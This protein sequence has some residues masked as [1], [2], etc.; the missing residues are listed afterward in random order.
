MNLVLGVNIV[1]HLNSYTLCQ[2]CSRRSWGGK[3]LLSILKELS[4]QWQSD[5]CHIMTNDP[6]HQLTSIFSPTHKSHRS[7]SR[8]FLLLTTQ[9]NEGFQNWASVTRQFQRCIYPS[10]NRLSAKF[11]P[12]ENRLSAQLSPTFSTNP[13]SKGYSNIWNISIIISGGALASLW[14]LIPISDRTPLQQHRLK[15]PLP[16]LLLAISKFTFY[17]FEECVGRG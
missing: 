10:G 9:L 12:Y 7:P 8:L 4:I 1:Q 6:P 2:S 17:S 13:S 5:H 3:I 14:K 16:N 11:N 15:L